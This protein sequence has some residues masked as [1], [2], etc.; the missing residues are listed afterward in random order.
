MARGFKT[1]Y[2]LDVSAGR[3]VLARCGRR[4]APQVALAAAADSDEARRALQ[5]AFKAGLRRLARR[6]SAALLR[7]LFGA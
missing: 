3:L 6:D 2:G 7:R 1:A 4:G 5:A